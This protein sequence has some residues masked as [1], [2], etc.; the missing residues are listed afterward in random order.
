MWTSFKSQK[1]ST[2]LLSA[3]DQGTSVTPL[4]WV[5]LL[6]KKWQEDE[7]KKPRY[8]AGDDADL[9]WYSATDFYLLDALQQ[10]KP[11]QKKRFFPFLSGFNANDKNA[12]T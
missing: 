3:M 10:L 1:E 6:A 5:Y 9:Y 2:L 11:Q 12:A 4:L 8:Y 7:P